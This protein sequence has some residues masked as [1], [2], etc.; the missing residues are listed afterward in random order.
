MLEMALD[1]A[2]SKG[3]KFSLLAGFMVGFFWIFGIVMMIWALFT[4]VGILPGMSLII[5]LIAIGAGCVCGIFVGVICM[6][7]HNG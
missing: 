2:M 3:V 4:I 7:N 1:Y 5:I 6:V